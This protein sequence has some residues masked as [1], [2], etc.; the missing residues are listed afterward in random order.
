MLTTVCV[1]ALIVFLPLSVEVLSGEQH[2]E[3]EAE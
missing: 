2:T 3:E 1:F